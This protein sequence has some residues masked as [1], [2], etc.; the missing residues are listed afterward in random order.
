VWP[1]E[2]HDFTPWLLGNADRLSEALC[3]EIELGAAEHAVGGYSLDLVGRDITNDAVLI[4]ENQLEQT[5]HSHLGQVLTYA[6]GTLASTIV[7]IATSFR[8]EHRQALT[9]LN[10]STDDK[11]HFFGIELQVVRIGASASA[12]LFKVVAQPND[13]QKQIRAVT[14]ATGLTG[15]GA[16]YTRFWE[17]FLA[18]VHA[19]H[20]DWT[21]AQRRESQNWFDMKSPVRGGRIIAS[22]AQGNRLRSELYIDTG[23]GD[24]NT[25]IFDQLLAR[26]DEIEA[27]YGGPLCWEQL[28]NRRACRAAADYWDGCDIA[29][30]D[31]WDEYIG[32]FIDTGVRLRASLGD[33]ARLAA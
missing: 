4:V 2:A 23:S 10:E 15:K 20:P 31:R 22:F 25:R 32:W 5:D 26:R 28:P 30:E 7:W 14:R 21:T 18:R 29:D 11:T 17:R 1:H 3:I 27:A 33:A 9:W 19:Q 6:A 24:D 8:E 16:L 13:W 12:P